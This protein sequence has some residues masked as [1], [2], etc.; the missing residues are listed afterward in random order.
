MPRIKRSTVEDGERNEGAAAAGGVLLVE[1]TV[2]LLG[3]FT[4]K[5]ASLSLTEL[6]ARASLHKS[7]AL[8]VAR[9]LAQTGYLVQLEDKTWRLGPAAGRLGAAYQQSFDLHNVVM[10][11][12]KALATDTGMTASFFVRESDT[13]TCVHRVEAPKDARPSVRPGTAFPLNK[14]APGRVILAFSGEAGAQYEAIRQQ[15][16]CVGMGERSTNDASVSA[17]VFGTNWQIVG[18]ISV[19]GCANLQTQ[20]GLQSLAT[21][22]VAAAA[23]ASRA[24]GGRY[25]RKTGR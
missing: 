17:P 13:R 9:T 2:R 5:E 4:G 8:R 24:L 11:L 3:C 20:A 12:L 25:V 14:G 19:S 1:R 15:G 6:S 23:R 18:A 16:F 10:P 21:A 22:V 7:T